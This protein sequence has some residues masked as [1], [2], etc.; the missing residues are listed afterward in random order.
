MEHWNLVNRKTCLM[1][2]SHMMTRQ[3]QNSG[4]ELNPC[5]GCTANE[6]VNREQLTAMWHIDNVKARHLEDKAS[7][8]FVNHLSSVH[9]N[10]EIGIT[11]FNNGP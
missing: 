1:A 7:L 8:E 11:K 6:V 3:H 10:K 9:A 2:L 4:F 5:D